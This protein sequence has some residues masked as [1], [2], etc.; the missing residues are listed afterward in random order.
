MAMTRM[1]EHRTKVSLFI[2][3]TFVVFTHEA[4]LFLQNHHN[5]NT[6]IFIMIKI[7]ITPNSPPPFPHRRHPSSY[8][9]LFIH[10]HLLL[11]HIVSLPC[12]MHCTKFPSSSSR[13]LLFLPRLT[14][15][16]NNGNRRN[17]D[18]KWIPLRRCNRIIS[19]TPSTP[20]PPLPYTHNS[21]HARADCSKLVR[22]SDSTILVLYVLLLVVKQV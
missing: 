6:D 4:H 2:L 9:P 3:V 14:K 19:L 17:F 10:L 1:M 18:D 20:P 21:D 11:V 8:R 5:H 15:A 22:L 16:G 7:T 13:L 12:W